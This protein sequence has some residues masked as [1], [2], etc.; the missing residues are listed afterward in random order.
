MEKMLKVTQLMRWDVPDKDEQ[1]ENEYDEEM[2][3]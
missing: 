1:N 2:G 3:N